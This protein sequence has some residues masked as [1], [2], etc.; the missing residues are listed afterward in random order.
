MAKSTE[1]VVKMEELRRKAN[2]KG[3]QECKKFYSFKLKNKKPQL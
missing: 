3:V 1:L 2:G